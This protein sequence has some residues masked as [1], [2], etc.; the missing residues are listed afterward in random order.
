[1]MPHEKSLQ[2][3]AQFLSTHKNLDIIYHQLII[4]TPY[5]TVY[6]IAT[7]QCDFYLKQTPEAL[8][9]E[10]KML[11]FLKQSGCDNTPEL[12]AANNILHCF[13][14]KPCGDESLRHIFNGTI[15]LNH[16]ILGISNYTKI[17][18]TLE[19][20][21]EQ[22]LSLNIPDWRLNIFPELYAKLTKQNNLLT[23]D[24]L[25]KKEIEQLQQRTSMCAELSNQLSQCNLPQTINHC[26]FHDNNMLLDRKSGA[27]TIIDWGEAV[28]SHPFFSLHGCLWNSTYFNNLTPSSPL[29]EKLQAQCISPWLDT[30]DGPTLNKAFNLSHQLRGIFA[31][32]AY[33]R[34]YIAT[35]NQ[36]E[37]VQ[38]K[39]KGAIAGCLRSFL[40]QKLP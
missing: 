7:K 38:Q 3:A 8:F 14:M 23:D 22:L 31:A 36:P 4:E 39:K 5:S 20:K 12:L 34:L 29:Y 24:G 2:W 28:I 40:S 1:M 30:H 27:I 6:R 33:E 35:N 37:T 13:L 18:R 19:N 17:Q 9:I 16:L 11:K 21:I 15:E 26:D 25:T 10:A 32:L